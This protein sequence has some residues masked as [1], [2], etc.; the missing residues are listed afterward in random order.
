MTGII[1]KMTKKSTCELTLK[2]SYYYNYFR[3]QL[4]LT[5]VTL[6]FSIPLFIDVNILPII[7]LYFKSVSYF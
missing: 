1:G 6:S 2:A 7:F 4:T 5:T 3:Q